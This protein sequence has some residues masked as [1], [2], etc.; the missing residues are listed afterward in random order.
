[1]KI[2]IVHGIG[3]KEGLK[4]SDRVWQGEWIQIIQ[5]SLNFHKTNI[6]LRKGEVLTMKSNF[7]ISM[8]LKL[9]N[10]ITFIFVLSA[11]NCNSTHDGYH[12]SK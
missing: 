6:E 2:L 1:M 10:T 12:V 11:F 5:N 7:E 4:E 9:K 8:S 3:Y